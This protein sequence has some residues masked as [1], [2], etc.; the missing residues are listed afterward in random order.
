MRLCFAR[1]YPD[2]ADPFTRIAGA[3]AFRC[4][5]LTPK[6]LSN[7]LVNSK[8]AVEAL[9]RCPAPGLLTDSALIP[10]PPVCIAE[11]TSETAGAKQDRFRV[12]YPDLS[13]PGAPSLRGD[14]GTSSRSPGACHEERAS[15]WRTKG[16][17]GQASASATAMS[18][19]ASASVTSSS[20][21][22]H[23]AQAS[24]TCCLSAGRVCASR[25]SASSS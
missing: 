5:V 13:M 12:L 21:R 8:E 15:A 1:L 14:C 3:S 10:I 16:G 23:R 6:A 4:I 2:S 22:M 7:N 17:T 11:A 18:R 19:S 24:S 9:T 20:A 25:S